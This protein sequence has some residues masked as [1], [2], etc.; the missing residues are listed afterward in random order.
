MEWKEYFSNRYK[1]G[2]SAKIKNAD[3]LTLIWLSCF[4]KNGGEKAIIHYIYPQSS[5]KKQSLK[6][7]QDVSFF[8][9]RV[10]KTAE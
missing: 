3:V 10:K 7:Q 9:L 2:N 5:K 8:N 6:T 1:E 4:V